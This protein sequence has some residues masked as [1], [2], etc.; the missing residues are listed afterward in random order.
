MIGSYLGSFYHLYQVIEKSFTFCILYIVK[1]SRIHYLLRFSQYF[2][3][4]YHMKVSYLKVTSIITNIKDG[5]Y[6]LGD[7][8]NIFIWDGFVYKSV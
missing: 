8:N 6:S 5:L 3:Q 1:L 7:P 2:Y 4:K